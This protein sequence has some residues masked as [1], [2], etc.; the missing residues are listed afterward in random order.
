MDIKQYVMC[1]CTNVPPAELDI[2]VKSQ[3]IISV[4]VDG[5]KC[6]ECG[7]EYYDMQSLK[8]IEELEKD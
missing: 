8:A 5:A 3:F 7:E 2:P 4:K 1:G 6:M